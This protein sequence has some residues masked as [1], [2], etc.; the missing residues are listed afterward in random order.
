MSCACCLLSCQ[1]QTTLPA[2]LPMLLP[3]TSTS[4]SPWVAVLN[5]PPDFI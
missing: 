1:V 3:L 2:N 5:A 4:G